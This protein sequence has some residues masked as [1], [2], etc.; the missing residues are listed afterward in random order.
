[1]IERKD[2]PGLLFGLMIP[3]V[4]SV[5]HM[6][7]FRMAIPTIKSH[8]ELPAD[9]A[10]WLAMAYGL[11][12]IVF[13]PIY[14]FLG[15][16]I[17]KKSLFVVGTVLFGIGGLVIQMSSNLSFLF[18][19]RATQGIGMSGIN[20]LCIAVISDFV[21]SERRGNALAVW[22]SSGSI[23]AIVGP[24]LGGFL[25]DRFGW[26]SIYWPVLG[27]C[28]LTVFVVAWMIPGKR[29][30]LP[31]GFLRRFD[32][33]GLVLFAVALVSFSIYLTSRPVTGIEPFQDWRLLAAAVITFSLLFLW[34]RRHSEPLVRGE[35]FGIKNFLKASVSAALRL[36]NFGSLIFLMPLYLSELHGL[37]ASSIGV[38]FT[39]MFCAL[40]LT[41][42]LGGKLADTWSARRT[43]MIGFTA[44]ILVM[45]YL[46]FLPSSI[47]FTWA[48]AGVVF[49]GTGS[50]MA[51]APTHLI[52]LYHVPQEKLGR[53]AGLYSTI[54]F[55]G[56]LLGPAVSGTLLQSGLEQYANPIMAYRRTF[57]IAAGVAVVGFVVSW[58]IEEKRSGRTAG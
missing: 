2:T 44:Q 18:V 43:V 37:R 27:L 16:R 50:G 5:V 23:A 39:L 29:V 13:M 51:L 11:P 36:F 1:M 19:G 4:T 49:F 54:R 57:L 31:E 15:D 46:F 17:G 10:A 28:I 25:I 52:S 47:S 58:L 24:T 7:M 30:K 14:G 45:L 40:F 35:L 32:W 55:G 33:I 38:I 3:F 42:R 21:P 26:R 6:F 53:A 34:E 22:N 20:P 48:A 56:S 41:L 8:F 9:L 12:Y